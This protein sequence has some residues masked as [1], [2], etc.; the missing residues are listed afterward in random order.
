MKQEIVGMWGMLGRVNEKDKPWRF[1]NNSRHLY[2]DEVCAYTE[3]LRLTTSSQGHYAYK[4][5]RVVVTVE[6]EERENESN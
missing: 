2:D 5:V 1:L 6:Y 4:P 3:A